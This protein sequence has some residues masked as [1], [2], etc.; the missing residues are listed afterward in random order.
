M[1]G[2]LLA[3]RIGGKW[4]MG[5]GLLVA[6]VATFL[7]PMAARTHKYLLCIARVVC[8]LGEVEILLIL[9]RIL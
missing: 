2:G 1:P 6:G 5:V 8:G 9:F 7:T 4:P 3:H